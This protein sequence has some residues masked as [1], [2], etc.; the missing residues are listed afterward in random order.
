MSYTGSDNG[1]M[2]LVAEK[3]IVKVD[4]NKETPEP[5]LRSFVA[6]IDFEAIEK[7]AR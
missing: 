6:A 4:G 3:V 7:L 1:F 5:T 2:T